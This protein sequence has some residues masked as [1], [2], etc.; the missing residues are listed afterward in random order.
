MT[1]KL[2]NYKLCYWAGWG[3]W[4]HWRQKGGG[5]GCCS[6]SKLYLV[7]VWNN[8]DFEFSQKVNAKWPVTVA[9][10]KLDVSGGRCCLSFPMR[11]LG[12][13]PCISQR[14]EAIQSRN[15]IFSFQTAQAK[16][17]SNSQMGH[18]THYRRL[19]CPKCKA[20][21][22]QFKSA[23]PQLRNIANNQ[24]HWGIVD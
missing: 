9:C 15:A 20:G 11:T 2:W 16:H 18:Q 12:L 4:S 21:H 8:S 6:A 3:G 13:R 19:V 1:Y 5:W 7:D 24:I 23:P 14:G 17:L 22:P 10:K